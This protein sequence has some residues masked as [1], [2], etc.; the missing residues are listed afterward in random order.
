MASK[1]YVDEF[2]ATVACS[3]R[4][5]K[6]LHGSGRAWAGDSWFMGVSE[7]EELLQPPFSLY[8]LWQCEDSHLAVPYQ[9]AD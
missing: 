3:M 9:R 7:V 5:S 2:G 8:P 4:L 6:Q 1:E